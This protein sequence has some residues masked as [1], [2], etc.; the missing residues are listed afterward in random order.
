[1]KAV[2]R[3]F[4]IVLSIGLL[5]GAYIWING[6][7]GVENTEQEIEQY[8]KTNG[9]NISEYPEALITLYERNPDAK[10]FVLGYPA[11][12]NKV[13]TI[14]LSSYKQS[15]GVPL[16]MQWDE[17]WG[18]AEYAGD[19]IGLSGCGPTCLSMVLLYVKGDVN[20]NPK[21]VADFATEEGYSIP[22]KGTDWALFTQGGRKLGLDVTELPLDENRIVRNLKVGNPIICA[23]G[24]GDFTTTGHFIVLSGYEDGKIKVNDPN[25]YKNSEKLWDYEE[26]SGQI[27]NL[28]AYR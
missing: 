21:T 13:H 5:V 22:G 25:S 24:P 15:K 7:Q 8:A 2:K 16:L 3:M 18:Y 27:K 10:D 9:I 14:N 19:M 4:R 26:I 11:N 6:F 12:K 17:S 23:M 1:M 20:M 28:W